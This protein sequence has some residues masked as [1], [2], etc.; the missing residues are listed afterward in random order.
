M[1]IITLVTV[2][3]LLHES[4]HFESTKHEK[5]INETR[6]WVSRC[7]CWSR[8]VCGRYKF[9]WEGPWTADSVLAAIFSETFLASHLCLLHPRP[10]S[11]PEMRQNFGSPSK[12]RCCHRQSCRVEK[13]QRHYCRCW[14][15]RHRPFDFSFVAE[16]YRQKLAPNFQIRIEPVS[17]GSFRSG[18]YFWWVRSSGRLR[19]SWKTKWKI[20]LVKVIFW[21][22]CRCYYRKDTEHL[23][24]AF[25]Y[26]LI[27]LLSC[28]YPFTQ[29]LSLLVTIVCYLYI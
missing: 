19:R 2:R 1:S 4:A 13:V 24:H 23:Y 14:T 16:D 21:K 18:V 22:Q 8:D 5:K 7:P 20:G 26:S 12:D 29:C 6:P 15:S 27:I 28:I 3:Q 9:R 25:V 10:Q 17:S 11:W